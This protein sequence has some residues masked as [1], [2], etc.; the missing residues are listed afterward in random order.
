MYLLGL[1]WCWEYTVSEQWTATVNRLCGFK[2][3]ILGTRF[4]NFGIRT[5]TLYFEM[6]FM[7]S[8]WAYIFVSPFF[9]SFSSFH[10]FLLGLVSFADLIT[11]NYR[12]IST[13]PRF[14]LLCVSTFLCLAQCSFWSVGFWLV[15]FY[16][17]ATNGFPTTQK[18]KIV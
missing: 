14:P 7:H 11:E 6:S 8:V 16:S 5:A 17:N 13:T 9:L 1:Y 2:F 3:F 12:A 10:L 4:Y 15:P 18:R